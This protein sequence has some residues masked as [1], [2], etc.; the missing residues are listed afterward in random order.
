M[1]EVILD[2]ES[3]KTRLSLLR[4]HI[5]RPL[6][7]VLGKSE[8]VEISNMNS[9]IF[10]YLLGYE[11]PETALLVS[12]TEAYAVTSPKKAL[13]LEQ[14]GEE[15]RVLVRSKNSSNIG[16]IKSQI[17]KMSKEFGVVDRENIKGT[18]CDMIMADLALSDV[19]REIL[20]LM[21]VK[22]EEEIE[23]AR[24]AGKN[25]EMF[26]QKCIDMVIQDQADAKRVT[27][28]DLGRRV[29]DILYE[30]GG[31]IEGDQDKIEFTYPPFLQSGCI[32]DL[33]N[34]HFNSVENTYVKYENVLC[35]IGVRY[36]GYCAEIGRTI[37]FNPE[38]DI[39]DDLNLAY[40]LQRDIAELVRPGVAVELLRSR[41]EDM[42]RERGL[43]GRANSDVLYSTGLYHKEEIVK[44]EFESGMVLVINLEINNGA[45]V[46]N[47][48]DTFHLG[49]RLHCIT[50]RPAQPESGTA[51]KT[52]HAQ[53]IM[54]RTD[55]KVIGIRVRRRD[56]DLEKNTRR[57]EHQ[58]ELLDRLIEEMKTYYRDAK[59]EEGDGDEE[60]VVYIPYK[61]ETLVPRKP[62]IAV[63]RKGEA[64][65]EG[66]RSVLRINFSQKESLK[67]AGPQRGLDT[68]K[69]ASYVASTHFIEEIFSQITEMKKSFQEKVSLVAQN[70]GIVEQ[71]ALKEAQGRRMVLTDVL[72]RTDARTG[73]RK[74]TAS[75]LELHENGLRFGPHPVEILVS[76]IK[77]VFFQEATVE[78]R[79]ILHFNL[80]NPLI[81]GKK[82]HNLQFYKE[83]GISTAHDTLKNKNDEYMEMVLEKEFED[84]K[85]A[86]NKEFKLFIEHIEENFAI[87]VEVPYVD[88]SFYGVPFRESV[89]IH[90]TNECLVSLVDAPFLV[91]TL[92]EIEIINFERV[93]YGVKTSDMVIILKDKKRP[94]ISILSIDSACISDLK[95]FFDS[96]NV[97]F[98]ETKVNIQWANLLKTIMQDPIAFYESNAW[99][100]L[101]SPEAE[102]NSDS[103]TD[104]ETEYTSI[105]SDFDTEGESDDDVSEEFEGEEEEDVSDE[106]DYCDSE[107]EDA[108][109]ESYES[110]EYPKKK[111]M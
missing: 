68:L 49:D 105:E 96:K 51:E 88:K 91:V 78:Q 71:E 75:N 76:N 17:G 50:S 52:Q 39:A 45:R 90:P 64:T 44:K 102:D 67:S 107:D 40:E 100:D 56:Q 70:Q 89:L 63:D 19:T 103:S 37:V 36:D 7:A 29:E 6:L 73:V 24:L 83:V 35:K 22:G 1:S 106:D 10:L 55:K 95:D 13:I 43:C 32:F 38:Q 2:K 33:G 65:E 108:E 101:I 12:K 109:E 58:K 26:M 99:Y 93:V 79:A 46:V 18:F 41:V 23:N 85:N 21:Q 92:G 69:S 80:V 20:D 11:L 94:P 14:L 98:L 5:S 61:K 59:L 3:F 86:I 104:V 53:P 16:D 54:I 72:M 30:D 9:A 57:A 74:N 111:R 48:T 81:I 77:H 60:D 66:D 110:Y 97:V 47:L 84:R 25:A 87:K 31:A 42:F 15:I 27:H 28:G 8:D 82:T 34:L 62:K 4:Q